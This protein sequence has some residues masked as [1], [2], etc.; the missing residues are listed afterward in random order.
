MNVHRKR[1]KVLVINIEQTTWYQLLHGL[2][3]LFSFTTWL[4]SKRG[5]KEASRGQLSNE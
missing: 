2:F 1:E 3:S 5:R 4:Q